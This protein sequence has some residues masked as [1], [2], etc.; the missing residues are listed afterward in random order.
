MSTTFA[1]T[2]RLAREKTRE[3]LVIAFDNAMA[4]AMEADARAAFAMAN[5]R[6]NDYIDARISEGVYALGVLEGVRLAATVL[7]VS[8][9]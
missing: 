4:D 3:A 5:T 2:A 7:G 8:L 1:R 9:D 6:D